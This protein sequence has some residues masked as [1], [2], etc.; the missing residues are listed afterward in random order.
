MD[1]NYTESSSDNQE[2]TLDI[3]EEKIDIKTPQWKIAEPNETNKN[4]NKITDFDYIETHKLLEAL[5]NQIITGKIPN[6]KDPAQLLELSGNCPKDIQINE[7][8]AQGYTFIIPEQHIPEFWEHRIWDDEKNMLSNYK[9]QKLLKRICDTRI[10][11]PYTS[12]VNPKIKT[13]IEKYGQRRNRQIIDLPLY[14]F[15]TDY[16]DEK[17]DFEELY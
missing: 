3:L 7:Q 16:L 15:T 2:P 1:K 4:H 17:T 14:D 8:K 6:Y 13:E 10:I 9:T 11:D 5:E 12:K